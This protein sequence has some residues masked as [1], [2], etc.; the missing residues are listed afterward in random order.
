LH[1]YQPKAE[2]NQ[3]RL[4]RTSP[5]GLNDVDDENAA[6]KKSDGKLGTKIDVWNV[7]REK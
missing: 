3:G 4:F 2:Q 5:K 7:G 1:K 6:G